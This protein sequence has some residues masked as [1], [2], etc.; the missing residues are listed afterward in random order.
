M[1]DQITAYQ[2]YRNRVVEGSIPSLGTTTFPNQKRVFVNET[3]Y[4]ISEPCEFHHGVFE[5]FLR[6]I[7]IIFYPRNNRQIKKIKHRIHFKNL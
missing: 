7:I 4:L 5:F 2:A 6:G 3:M 1:A